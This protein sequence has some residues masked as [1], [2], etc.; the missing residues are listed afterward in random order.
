[1][2]HQKS[3]GT[4]I[5][6][7]GLSKRFNREWIFRNFNYTFTSGNTYAITGPNGSGKS[8]LQQVLWGQLPA[9]S[10]T[11]TYT[12]Q[13]GNIPAEEIYQY[14][15]VAAP[16]M[17]LINEFTLFEQLQFHFKLKKRRNGLCL[18]KMMEL[19]Y[20][21]SARDKYIVNF[22]SGM[23]QRLKL[24]LTFFTAADIIFLDEPGTNLDKQAFDWYLSQLNDLDGNCLVFIASNHPAEYPVNATK[25]DILIHK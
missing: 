14:I 17:D 12:N 9:T 25:I 22:S 20:L 15:S 5:T 24:A 8:T 2:E 10:G 6:V 13:N 19:M 23:K 18:E 3:A 21:E 4:S 11:L 1:M 16:Y 7:E